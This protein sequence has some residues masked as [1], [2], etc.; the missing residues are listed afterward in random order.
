M[1]YQILVQDHHLPIPDNIRQVISY[2]K[3]AVH[4][5]DGITIGEHWGLRGLDED[6]VAWFKSKHTNFVWVKGFG[7]DHMD[8]RVWQTWTVTPRFEQEPTAWCPMP[9]KGC[10]QC[11]EGRCCRS[12]TVQPV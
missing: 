2:G 6:F 10:Y 1:D 4:D 7:K 12:T 8:G 11:P 9:D 5:R 3:H